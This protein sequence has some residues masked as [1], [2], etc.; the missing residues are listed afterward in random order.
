[1]KHLGKLEGLSIRDSLVQ[2]GVVIIQS[3]L[4]NG[5]L[6]CDFYHKILLEEFFDTS[7]PSKQCDIFYVK[8]YIQP[9]H[10]IK[11]QAD[12]IKKCVYLPHKSGHVVLSMLNNIN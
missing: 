8:G 4:H 7:I 2:N 10:I 6:V 1:M 11:R 9:Q 3:K 5:D 12:F